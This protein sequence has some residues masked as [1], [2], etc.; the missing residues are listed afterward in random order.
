MPQGL[1]GFKEPPDGYVYGKL[2]ELHRTASPLGGTLWL[3]MRDDTLN[4][5]WTKVSGAYIPPEPSPTPT[6]TV[7]ITPTM[8]PTPV[9]T[10]TPTPTMTMTV[11][12]TITL[13]VTP[14]IDTSPTPTPTITPTITPSPT[15]IFTGI[16]RTWYT[17]KDC[18]GSAFLTEPAAVNCS[19][20]FEKPEG[21]GPTTPMSPKVP[22]YPINIPPNDPVWSCRMS[23]SLFVEATDDYY[24]TAFAD[25]T[26]SVYIDDNFIQTVGSIATATASLSAG[27]HRFEARYNNIACCLSMCTIQWKRASAGGYHEMY[28]FANPYGPLYRFSVGSTI[29]PNG[30]ISSYGDGIYGMNTIISAG[31]VLMDG[32]EFTGWAAEGG[33]QVLDGTNPSR[34]L[35]DEFCKNNCGIT[36]GTRYTGVVSPTPTATPAVTPTP[37][38]VESCTHVDMYSDSVNGEFHF[39][40]TNCGGGSANSEGSTYPETHAN[41]ADDCVRDGT[42]NIVNGTAEYGSACS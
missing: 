15:P 14:S 31:V 11:T 38:P 41:I 26:L 5:G 27:W 17:E 29:E 16:Y 3:K 1:P 12:P 18:S 22:G 34:I 10:V 8:T 36:A 4:T 25:D 28:E 30:I 20:Q 19:F 9:Y 6:P 2:G 13:T 32:W 23:A 39:T 40:W 24:I 33:V 42:L 37:L 7:S 35:L 21:G